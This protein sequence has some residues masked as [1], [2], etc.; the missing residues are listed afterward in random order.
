MLGIAGVHL[1][2]ATRD[3]A[4]RHSETWSAKGALDLAW[5]FS[6]GGHSAL[7]LG[8]EAGVLLRRIPVVTDGQRA[9]LGGLWGAASVGLTFP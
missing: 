6:L 7:E 4:G 9:E 1:V 8:V 3:E 2:N 5:A